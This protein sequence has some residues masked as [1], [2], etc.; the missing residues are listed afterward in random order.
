[1]TFDDHNGYELPNFWEFYHHGSIS[2]DHE[3]LLV[4][5]YFRLVMFVTDGRN[6]VITSEF[7]DF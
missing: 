5:K 1:V 6:L 4:L 3:M 2:V 7:S